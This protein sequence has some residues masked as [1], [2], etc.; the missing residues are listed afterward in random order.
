MGAILV[1]VLALFLREA[2][3]ATG[4]SPGHL[5][6]NIASTTTFS[7]GT[8]AVRLSATSSC[9]ARLVTSKASA[10]HLTFSEG[11]PQRPT[12]ELGYFQA[13][14]TSAVYPAENFGCG[15]MYGL[16]EVNVSD[17]TITEAY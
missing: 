17:V 12:A 9:A 13:T 6:A 3:T 14:G 10:I 16:V 1:V 15:T 5:P 7:L 8:T 2:N 11:D 4:A